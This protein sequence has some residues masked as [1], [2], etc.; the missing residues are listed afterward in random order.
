MR[1]SFFVWVLRENSKLLGIE[2]ICHNGQIRSFAFF[3]WNYNPYVISPFFCRILSQ[4]KVKYMPEKAQ[5]AAQLPQ[6]RMENRK[7]QSELAAESH[8]CEKTIRSLE[9]ARAN[10]RLKTLKRI[11][12]NF[13]MSVSA[14]LR[15][16]LSP[17]LVAKLSPNY[18]EDNLE[19]VT[20]EIFTL[21]CWLKVFLSF[22]GE[23]QQNFSDHSDVCLDTISR[24]IR[25]LPSC[26]PT[27]STLQNFA[28]YMSITV[29][30]L[31]D[32]TLSEYDM[33]KLLKERIHL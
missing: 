19:N 3:D 31:L 10:P 4:K 13:G 17:S 15:L 22:S 14:F 26:N 1:S 23:T 20:D 2:W 18:E 7:F 27:L 9:K 28:A 21:S 25:R 30:E 11:V 6:F 24:L 12:S 32:T 29:S 8:V 33:R 5:I 16:D